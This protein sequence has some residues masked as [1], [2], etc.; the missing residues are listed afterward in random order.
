MGVL[1]F[2]SYI[3]FCHF[4]FF[5]KTTCIFSY[6]LVWAMK[7]ERNVHRF[8]IYIQPFL[9]QFPGWVLLTCHQQWAST[10]YQQV[11]QEFTC[12]QRFLR[13]VSLKTTQSSSEHSIQNH[14]HIHWIIL[15]MF[16]WWFSTPAPH[17]CLWWC[18]LLFVKKCAA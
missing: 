8:H 18:F 11:H 4:M 5:I 2:L 1:L 6:L 15:G 17:L 10:Y 12:S 7:H 16:V 13:F 14:T 9:L 3:L